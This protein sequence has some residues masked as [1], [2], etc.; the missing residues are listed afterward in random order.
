MK[1]AHVTQ[2]ELRPFDTS[3]HSLSRTHTHGH[4]EM[5]GN[6]ALGVN[7]RLM[8]QLHWLPMSGTRR[9]VSSAPGHSSCASELFALSIFFSVRYFRGAIICGLWLIHSALEQPLRHERSLCCSSRWTLNQ[10]T[11][12]LTSVHNFS[13]AFVMCKHIL[14]HNATFFS[15]FSLTLQIRKHHSHFIVTLF[16]F[17]GTMASA[18]ARCW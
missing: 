18:T 3:Q 5:C 13:R 9:A 11:D 4:G 6:F 15:S 1:I 17:C 10:T 14:S 12:R 2:P 8:V 7:F 16:S